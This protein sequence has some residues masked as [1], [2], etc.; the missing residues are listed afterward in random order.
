M[1]YQDV[2][3]EHQYCTF[4]CSLQSLQASLA[5]VRKIS[6]SPDLT[7]TLRQPT[8]TDSATTTTAATSDHRLPQTSIHDQSRHASLASKATSLESLSQERTTAGHMTSTPI[9]AMH[10]DLGIAALTPDGRPR[11]GDW[12]RQS[13]RS[14]LASGGSTKSTGGSSSNWPSGE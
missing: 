10:S 11:S 6:S 2:S 13:R 12:E 14:L 1:L 3:F 5:A 7:L 4:K 9:H 8:P